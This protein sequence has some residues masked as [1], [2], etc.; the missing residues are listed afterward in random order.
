MVFSRVNS[1]IVH[2]LFRTDLI[3]LKDLQ[4]KSLGIALEPRRRFLDAHR[5]IFSTRWH[6]R[7]HIT[8][9][10]PGARL[11]GN[12]SRDANVLM[13]CHVSLIIPVITIVTYNMRSLCGLIKV[14]R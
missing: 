13:V 4:E 12:S 8:F 1:R 3:F 7:P 5:I 11:L 14:V 6:V 10:I 2:N 9:P